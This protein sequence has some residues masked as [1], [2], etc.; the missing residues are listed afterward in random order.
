MPVL[1]WS[2]PSIIIAFLHFRKLER[3]DHDARYLSEMQQAGE[4][5]QGHLIT[6][7]V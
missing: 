4:A 2:V 6:A 7:H 1:D 5:M 3:G